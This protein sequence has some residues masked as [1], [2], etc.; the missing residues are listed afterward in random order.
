MKCLCNLRCQYWKEIDMFGKEPEFYYKG[1]PKKTSW[2]GRIL[3]ILFVLIYFAFLLY[4]VIRM[5]QKKDVTFYDTFTYV[6]EPSKV[7]ITKENFYGG[8]A[9]E[10]PVTYDTFI[11]ESIYIPKAYF[12]RAEKKGDIFNW[13]VIELEL[14]PCRLEKFGSNYQDKFKSKDL[15]NLYC[16]KNMDFFLEGHFSYDLYSFLYFEFYPCVNTSEKQNCKPIE[17]IDYFLKSTFVQFEWQDIELNSKNYSYPI[18]PRSADIYTTVR[19]KLFREIH[20]FFQVVRIETDL[21]FIGFDEF[22]YMKT[23]VYLKYDEMAIMSNLIEDDIYKT[24]EHFCDFTIKLS[25]NVRIHKRTYTKLITILGDVG[26]LMEVVFTLFRL[27]ASL[28][29]DILYDIS[30]V[31]NLFNFNLAQKV[32]ILKDK[33]LK[34]NISPKDISHKVILPKRKIRVLATQNPNSNTEVDKNESTK[35]L[36]EKKNIK[37]IDNNDNPSI[38]T[39]DN[40]KQI[41]KKTHILQLKDDL[42]NVF[43]LIKKNMTNKDGN[44]KIRYTLNENNISQRTKREYII[45]KIKMTRGCVYFCFCC[46]R[47]RKIIQNILLDE[48]MN[49]ISEKLDIFNIFEQL[50]KNEI[51]PDKEKTNQPDI[52]EMS[53][54]CI[55]KLNSFN[56]KLYCESGYANN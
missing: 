50:Y 4:K 12:K 1:R 55:F 21:D 9:L 11:D 5:W 23:D 42:N 54:S 35:R 2:M 41:R 51:N 3:S 45:D 38:V 39:F 22:D 30:L 28:S 16:I 46:A 56:N 33:K 36:S 10:D 14:E 43:S 44:N 52:I 49:I 40:L 19:K 18:N 8:F 17:T 13:D 7:K 34:Q 24:G 27:I 53:D 31:N 37:I 20:A 25:E 32:V 29:L 26:G 6:K 47:K 48:G 15:N